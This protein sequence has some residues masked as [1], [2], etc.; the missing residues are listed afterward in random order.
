M[1]RLRLCF[2]LNM[3]SHFAGPIFRSRLQE[4]SV[5]GA[6]AKRASPNYCES[7][8]QDFKEEMIVIV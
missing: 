7:H 3:R 5:V 1:K 6:I 4:G 2:R 8:V